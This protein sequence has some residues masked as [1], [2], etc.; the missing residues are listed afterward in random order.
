MKIT[1]KGLHLRWVRRGVAALAFLAVLEYLVLPQLAGTRS[2]LHLLGHVRLV[3][4]AAG[5]GLEAASLA[6]YSML[7]RSV[8]S[9]H[10][11]TYLWLLRTDLTSLGIS[12]VLPGGAAA[13]STLR[14]RL[15]REGGTPAQDAIVGAAVQGIGS[16]V[17]L[18]SLLWLALVASLIVVAANPLYVAAAAV[19]A[20]VIA[21][22]AAAVLG[23][24]RGQARMNALTLRFIGR[25]PARFRARTQQGL[26]NAAA[27]LVHLL[28]D[29]AALGRSAAWAAANWLLDA[30]SLG[31]FLAAY[32]WHPNPIG[33]LVGYGL[34]NVLAAVPISPGGLGVIE[35]ILIPTLV[36][37][38][39]PRSIALLGVVSWRLFNFW[40]PI[41]VSGLSYA[42][43]RAQD[44]GQHRGPARAWSALADLVRE[45]PAHSLPHDR[46]ADA[47][48]A[49]HDPSPGP[50]R[51]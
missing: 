1:V 29:R 48:T 28:A 50:A 34:A 47:A 7:T 19:G 49:E 42:S 4:V 46:S 14:Y 2:A 21:G 33:L 15:L 17:V 38:G 5:V 36:G 24:S 32:G 41:P 35:G 3:W 27:Q 30:A 39:S 6:S 40:A 31:V 13:G 9:H 20:V 16:A 12:H 37:F 10:R 11:P 23:L 22:A 25:V 43:L 51:P 44:W 8:L 18:V 26:D 45:R